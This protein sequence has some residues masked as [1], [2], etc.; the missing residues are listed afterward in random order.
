MDRLL[1]AFSSLCFLLS[2]S[3]T[4][5]A[6]GAR[7]FRA[8]RFNYMVILGGFAFQTAFLQERGAAIGGCPL[9]NLFEVLVFLCW[10]VALIYLVIGTTYRHSL[11]GAF[12]APMIFC[13]QTAAL[14]LPIDREPEPAAAAQTAAAGGSSF[15]LEL[16]AA[17]SLMAYGAFAL[18]GIA[19]IM[20]LVQERQLKTRNLNSLFYHLPPIR[21]LGKVNTRLILAGFLL[22]T[23]GLLAGFA[24]GLETAG[25]KL[26]AGIG[27]WVLYGIILQLRW[28]EKVAPRRT[29]VLSVLAFAVSFLTL[30]GFEFVR[31]RGGAGV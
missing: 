17:V 25:I 22:L 11:M 28:L 13:I 9:T 15:W 3:W 24:V 10:S 21:D 2:F 26:I 30:W 5:Y 16:H 23:A 20:Y 8:S 18:A 29:A 1:L 14:V 31:A 4:M 19:G 6:L 12:T 27:V 7:K